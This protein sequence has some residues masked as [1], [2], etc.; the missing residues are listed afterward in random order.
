[1]QHAAMPITGMPRGVFLH[2]WIYHTCDIPVIG[3][4]VSADCMWHMNMAHTNVACILAVVV[5][6][7]K[8]S[9]VFL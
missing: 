5:C 2:A 8:K 3:V 7:K 1:M 9:Y 6:E 4:K